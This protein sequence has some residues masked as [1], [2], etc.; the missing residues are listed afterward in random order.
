MYIIYFD[1]V[2]TLIAFPVHPPLQ[3]APPSS[4]LGPYSHFFLPLGRCLPTF[5]FACVSVF[6]CV[7]CNPLSLI[8]VSCVSMGEG[9]LEQGR[10]ISAY[11]TKENVSPSLVTI[12]SLPSRVSLPSMT[13]CRQVQACAG[14]HSLE[15]MSAIAMPT[16]DDI[17]TA[18]LRGHVVFLLHLLL[19]PIP[20][21]LKGL[22]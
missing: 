5:F 9:L 14:N 15:F 21:A 3:W 20:W 18:F 8:M 16:L 2:Q 4:Q 10:L 11:T 22:I 19:R 1:Y 6:V 12:N 13:D 17:G 7:S